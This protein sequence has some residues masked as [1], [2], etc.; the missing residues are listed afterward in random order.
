M[1][2]P[3]ITLHTPLTE[4]HGVGP[5]RAAALAKL[6]LHTTADLLA[7]FPR[8]YEDRTLRESIAVLPPDAPAAVSALI[9]EPLRTSYLRAGMEVT[10]G[11]AVDHTGQLELTF[12]NQS[13]VR[14]ALHPGQ[15][16]VFYGQVTGVGLHRQMTNPRFE[17]EGKGELTGGITPVYPRSA[18]ISQNFLI[19]L[20]RTAFP[21]CLDQIE[22][23]LPPALR[24][25]HRLIDAP[26]AYRSI[27]LPAT[28]ADLQAARRRLMFEELFC[29]NL[30]LTYLRTRRESESALSFPNQDLAVL[31]DS[32]PFQLTQAQ[33]RAIDEAA[34]DL[35]KPTPM[36]RLLQ[37]DVGSGKTVV[38]A[39]CALFAY[40]NGCQAAFM[41]P[42]E[43]LAHQHQAT[44]ETLLR[45][46]GL[47]IALL[48]GS[49]TPAQK[50]QTTA[51]LAAGEI[52]LVVGTHALLSEG[53]QFARLGL[54][55]TDEQHRFG[56]GQRAALAAKSGGDLHPHV[57]VMSATPIPRTLA[58]ML[59]GDLDLSLLNELPPGRTPV[60]TYLIH[61]NK[62]PRLYNFVRKQVALGRQV[63]I[64]CPAVSQEDPDGL[65]AAEQYGHALQTEVFPD[66]RVGIVHG[67]QRSKEKQAVMSAF[68]AG[69]LDVLVSTTVIEVGV[70]VPNASLM[71][72]ENADRF[73][74]S[75]LHQLR[76]R[77]GRGSAKSW[78]VLLSDSDNEDTR[79]RLK[80]LTQTND[81]FKISEEDLRLRGPGDFFGQRQHGLPT[82]KAADLSCDM[83]LLE[84]AQ[85]AANDLLDGDPSLSAPAHALLRR[86]IDRL[87]AVN[88]GGLN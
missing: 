49:M 31:T 51:A 66:L 47:R 1:P 71:V 56:V 36:S 84:E 53:V 14:R 28:W 64:V 70:D 15:A 26:Q 33:R 7:Y 29:L 59:Y 10:K 79:R 87:F 60:E 50:R 35:R 16:Y 80:V 39:A 37:G 82:L 46:A 69:D 58:L 40:Q 81:G 2:K 76:G 43:L 52:D 30:G 38:A 41:A 19:S 18:G 22:D 78:C 72:I 8:D 86:R 24:A 27:H 67:K 44:L 34:A 21:A 77:V 75:Q 63:Y 83:R 25:E 42:T 32:L 48:I 11:R 9:A 55:I 3:A 65:K 13:Y 73:G 17:P 85:S 57:L 62:R 61:E 4:F 20:L 12:F 54:V 23:P 68:A 6:G 74:L 88:E 5:T 45:Q